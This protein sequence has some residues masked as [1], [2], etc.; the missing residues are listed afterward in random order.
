LSIIISVIMIFHRNHASA[1]AWVVLPVRKPERICRTGQAK[2]PWAWFTHC[3][4][5][6]EALISKSVVPEVQ[7]YWIRQ[8]KWLTTSRAGRYNRGYFQYYVLPWKLLTHN[9]Y[10]TW[11][12]G[13]YLEG[14]CSQGSVKLGKSSQLFS[15]LK[16]LSWL[17]CLVM[18]HG[19][20]KLLSYLT[21]PNDNILTCTDT[22]NSLKEKVTLCGARIKKGNK[23]ELIESWKLD[24][25]LVDLILKSLPLLSKNTEK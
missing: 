10:C 23:V 20:I 9:S 12:W 24:K 2:E 25:N 7:K 5:H 17:T 22:V 8:S 1:Y 11:K 19:A 18:R 13:G 16:S 15:H 4:L 14:T 3:F 6:R 21:S